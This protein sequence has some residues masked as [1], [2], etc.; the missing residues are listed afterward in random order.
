MAKITKKMCKGCPFNYGDPS[1]E[2]AYNLGCLPSTWEVSVLCRDN[3]TAWACHSAPNHV[4]A[5]FAEDHPT[6]T[7]LPLHHMEG[8]HVDNK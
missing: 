8:V 4:C 3:K 2:M 6:Q 1:T 7:K 5:G